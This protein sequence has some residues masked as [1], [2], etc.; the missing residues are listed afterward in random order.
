MSRKRNDTPLDTQVGGGHYK[1]MA[2]QPFTYITENNLG[3]CEGNIVKY[4]SRYQDKGGAEDLDKVIHYAQ[5]LKELK[6]GS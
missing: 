6:Y 2:I 1:D 5:M 3:F 4:I